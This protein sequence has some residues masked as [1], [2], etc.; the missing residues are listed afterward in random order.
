MIGNYRF[1]KVESKGICLK[2]GSVS[3]L[4]KNVVN[5]YTSYELDTWSRNLNTEFTL[6]NCLFG[7]VKLTKNSDLY[8]YGYSGYGTG[9]DSRSQLSWSDSGWSK[10][11]II[12][13]TDMISSAHVDDK[14]KDILVLVKGP[15]QGLVIPR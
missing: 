12:F 7:A 15:T 5:L 6:G 4:H 1:K 8:K 13:S 14:N 11:V 9:L 3:F 2:Q 10:N